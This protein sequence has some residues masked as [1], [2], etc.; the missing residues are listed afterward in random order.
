MQG[1]QMGDPKAME[2]LY[3]MDPQTAMAI[4][5]QRQQQAAS[6][7]QNKMAAN[8]DQRKRVKE[9]QDLL[10]TH[11][12]RIEKMAPESQKE[13]YEREI[14][15]IKKQ[16]PEVAEYLPSE[17]TEEMQADIKPK[18]AFAGTG[19]TAQ[20]YNI[21]MDG[22]PASKEYALAYAYA[23]RPQTMQTEQ[24]AVRIEPEIPAGVLPPS[25]GLTP[26]E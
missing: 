13:Y 24:G 10:T 16:Y 22:D 14:A 9:V 1:A 6:A 17:F 15:N 26:T 12:E 5:K 20:S 2:G 7:A 23:N 18:G 19:M 8:V 4:Q 21:L 11:Q 25:Y 3:M